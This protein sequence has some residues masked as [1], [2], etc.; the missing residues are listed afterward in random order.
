MV[1]KKMLLVGFVVL[2]FMLGF[3]VNANA[4]PITSL[5]GAEL[6]FSNVQRVSLPSDNSTKRYHTDYKLD[7][8][9]GLLEAFCVED[10]PAETPQDYEVYSLYDAINNQSLSNREGSLYQAAYIAENYLTLLASGT[11]TNKKSAAQM[12]IWELTLD[13]VVDY[14]L[15]SD[16]DNKGNVWSKSPLVGDAE[17]LLDE[18]SSVFNNAGN[19]YN[20]NY[21]DYGWAIAISP[22]S[23][24]YLIKNPVPEPATIL[25]LGIGLVGLGTY[26]RKFRKA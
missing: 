26:T 11:T 24:N 10:T 12:A 3:Q 4:G 7:T 6:K 1:P 14:K 5:S 18:V 25:L 17:T 15:A 22:N 23:Q 2:C 8:I 21:E 9:F 19:S 20:N 16:V 13:S